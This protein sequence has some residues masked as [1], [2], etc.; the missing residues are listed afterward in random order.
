ASLRMQGVDSGRMDKM[1]IVA[2][3]FT[4]TSGDFGSLLANIATKAMLKGYE[5]A[6]ET[7]QKWTSVGTL[8]DFKAAKRVDLDM[9]PALEV[10]PEGGE[11]KYATV[12]DRGET[13]QLATFGKLFGISRHSIVNDDLNAFTNVP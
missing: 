11:Y 13:V 12:G 10:V 2:A 9:F 7:F 4:H 6:E 8:P 3:A 5:E 1:Q